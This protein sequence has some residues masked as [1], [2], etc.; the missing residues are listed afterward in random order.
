MTAA[1]IVALLLILVF[2]GRELQMPSM[3][4]DLGGV[5]PSQDGTDAPEVTVGGIGLSLSPGASTAG[6]TLS[7]VSV[8]SGDLSLHVPRIVTALDMEQGFQGLIRPRTVRIEGGTLRMMRD[9]D[10][11]LHVAAGPDAPMLPVFDA[12][13]DRTG[14]TF[15]L[16]E[17]LN[18]LGALGSEQ[19]LAT[20]ETIDLAEMGISFHDERH[21]RNWRTTAAS[22]DLAREGSIIRASVRADIDRGGDA[23]TRVAA[24]VRSDTETHATSATFTFDEA[25]PAD[26]A[27]QFRALDWMSVIDAPVSGNIGVALQGDGTLTEMAGTLTLGQGAITAETGA[28]I[29]FD[30]AKAYFV[31]DPASD[32]LR[33]DATEIVSDFGTVSGS[34]QILLERG[35]AGNVSHLVAQMTLEGLTVTAEPLLERPMAFEG[36]TAVG[37]LTIEPLTI[38]VGHAALSSPDGTVTVSAEARPAGTTWDLAMDVE[39]A[40]LPYRAALDLWPPQLRP[41]VRTWLANHIDQGQLENLKLF[42]RVRDKEPDIAMNFDFMDAEVRILDTLP[43][44]RAARGTGT[45]IDKQLDLVLASGQTDDGAGRII[46]LTGSRFQ[47]PTFDKKPVMGHAAIRGKGEIPSFLNLIEHR[48]LSLMTLIGKDPGFATGQAA[49]A[50]DL[51]LPL[52]NDLKPEQVSYEVAADLFSV[53]STEVVEDRIVTAESLTLELDPQKIRVAGAARLDELPLRFAYERAIADNPNGIAELSGT[54]AVTPENLGHLGI[55][56]P[57][58]S[59]GGTGQARYTLALAGD[60]TNPAFNVTADLT[61]SRL[62]V[63]A[64][65]WSKRPGRGATLNLRGAL[66]EP[67]RVDALTFEGPGL[68]AT[69]K[70]DLTTTA[71]RE[72]RFERLRAGRWLD[73]ALT[74]R[75]TGPTSSAVSINGGTIDLRS[76]PS[77]DGN[78]G[79]IDL[80]MAADRV[81][82]TDGISLTGFTGRI[83]SDTGGRG[84]FEARVNGGA[85]VSG[86]I[87]GGKTVYLQSRDGG[88][89]LRD[90]GVFDNMQGGT[91]RVSLTQLGTGVYDGRFS[92]QNSRAIDA[93]VL[94]EILSFINPLGLIDRLAGDGIGFDDAQGWFTLSKDHITISRARAIGPSLGVTLSGVYN[95]LSDRLDMEGVVS[96][97]YVINGL[98]ARLPLLGRLLGG[99][100]GEGLLGATFQ[101]R[102]QAS[103][104]QVAVNPLSILTPG[105]AREIFMTRPAIQPADPPRQ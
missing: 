85:A 75:P 27:T 97:F 73:T 10:G 98:P 105:A 70:L 88:R 82:V 40:S 17:L 15:D 41:G 91:L 12:A 45:I 26:L 76:A 7:D 78:G 56:L 19:M 64:L 95:P 25:R 30:Y 61:G 60:G 52:I 68:S 65:A 13:A 23:P 31:Y 43:P 79:R 33:V 96:P 55:N 103:D 89:A 36:G 92:L 28:K 4:A 84:R 49:V 66:T 102:G 90:A 18:G 83:D 20:L 104:P 5:M 51:R 3:T 44:I 71:L 6:I 57:P 37:R 47:I 16:A 100:D 42:L 80:S 38:E 62:S 32:A 11:M 77:G 48:P 94:A 50:A 22:A 81:I 9:T 35:A 101:L 46:D 2:D 53:T 39:T 67:V 1:G 93:P 34:G 72:A 86:V 69:G 58:G 24:R 29:A 8:S 59:V 21:D 74:Y 99:R 87:R 14:A 63:P 54:V